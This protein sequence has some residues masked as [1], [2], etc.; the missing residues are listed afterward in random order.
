MIIYK[1]VASFI[2]LEIIMTL[3]VYLL[4]RSHYR[5]VVDRERKIITK[6]R[7][8]PS[9]NRWHHH[10]MAERRKD[11][12]ITLD[13][14]RCTVRIVDFGDPSLQAL[15][16]KTISAELI[17]ISLGGLKFSC[18]IN[19]PVFENVLI[20]ISFQ[21]EDEILIYLVGTVVRKEIKH[22]R[23]NIYYGVQFRNLTAKEETAIQ[24]YINQKELAKRKFNMINST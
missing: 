21:S 10:F 2:G 17:D 22:G 1:A 16:D 7:G 20:N 3:I 12:R 13:H 8:R 5:K 14:E 9:E 6:L 24:N 18:G 4:L 23:T 15:N 19:F 11:H